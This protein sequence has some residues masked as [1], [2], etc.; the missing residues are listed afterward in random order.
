V[1]RATIDIGSNSILLLIVTTEGEVILDEARVVGLGRGLGD[2]GM[3]QPQR[4]EAALTVLAE[5]ADLA[6]Q[7][8]V[9]AWMVKAVATSGARRALNARAFLERVRTRTGLRVR[10]VTGDEEAW[11]TWAGARADLPL[12]SGPLAVVDPGGGSTELVLGEGERVAT[13]LSLELGVVRLTE[14]HFGPNPD[15]YRPKQLAR[16]REEV[17]GVLAGIEW[18]VHPRALIAVAGTVTTIAA[19][20]RGL[21]E[22]QRDA[23]HGARLSR[24]VFRRW[25]DRLLDSTPAER[26]AWAAVAPQRA[27]YL[28]AGSCLLEEICTAAHRDSLLV[29]DGGVR[30]GLLHEF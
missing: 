9:P 29:S 10:V 30:Y 11:L 25:V 5:Y 1:N 28:L 26:R 20:H 16:L 27:D 24:G 13:K 22:W 3:L 6:A 17:R 12:P 4:M 14:R 15:R 7:H 21:T 23:I 2:G 19:M 8:S 18:T